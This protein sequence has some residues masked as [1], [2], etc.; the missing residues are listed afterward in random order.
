MLADLVAAAVGGG[1]GA[2]NPAPEPPLLS[3]AEDTPAVSGGRAPRN[4]DADEENEYEALRRRNIE[5]HA[6]LLQVRQE[7]R[8]C[9]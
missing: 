7:L 8:Q 6:Q 1:G 3:H 5:R 2:A 9:T 4:D